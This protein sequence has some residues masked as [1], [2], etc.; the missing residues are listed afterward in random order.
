M[1]EEAQEVAVPGLPEKDQ[2]GLLNSL[3]DGRFIRELA[4]RSKTVRDQTQLDCVSEESLDFPLT[5]TDYDRVIMGISSSSNLPADSV[6]QQ[7]FNN[8]N[9][10]RKSYR[11]Y[12]SMFSVLGAFSANAFVA[13]CAAN[14]AFLCLAANGFFSLVSVNAVYSVA[15]MNCAFCIASVNS[16]FAVGCAGASFKVC[17][18]AYDG[19]ETA[20]DEHMLEAGHT[21]ADEQDI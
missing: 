14:G 16:C 10:C 13:F 7:C 12:R 8:A 3:I 2:F 21:E 19:T 17:W 9:H 20:R 11:S 5:M 4:V 6:R 15:S 1:D 18:D